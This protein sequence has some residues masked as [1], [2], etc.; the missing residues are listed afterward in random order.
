MPTFALW[1]FASHP[2]GRRYCRLLEGDV[3][4]LTINALRCRPFLAFARAAARAAA[5]ASV[6]AAALAAARA[7]ASLTTALATAAVAAAV[8]AAAD[9]AVAA[10]VRAP[11]T[12]HDARAYALETRVGDS[13]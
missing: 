12:E 2:S 6:L 3:F 4:I 8:A 11:S 10:D 7:A 5:L 13:L 9:S 1:I